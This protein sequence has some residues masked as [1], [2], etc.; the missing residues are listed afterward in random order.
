[1][2][3]KEFANEERQILVHRMKIASLYFCAPLVISFTFVDYFFAPEKQLLFLYARLCVIPVCLIVYYSYSIKWIEEKFP[4]GPAFLLA[5]YFGLYSAFLVRE[6]GYEVSSYYA[7]INLVAIIAF[8]FLPWKLPYVAV[9]T[10]IIYSPY[11]VVLMTAPHSLDRHFWVPNLAF[12]GSTCFLTISSFLVTREL[13]KKEIQAR[14]NLEKQNREQAQIIDQKTREGVFME[15]LANQFA[16]QIVEAIKNGDLTLEKTSRREITCL[17]LDIE[18]ST[19]RSSRIDYSLYTDLMGEFFSDCITLFLKQ[20]VTIGTFLGDG[21]LAFANAPKYDPDHRKNVIQAGLAI[22]RAHDK[23]KNYYR[24]KWRTDFNVRIGIETGFATVGFF[25]NKNRG[26]YT[27]MGE[28]VNLTSRLCS[29]AK[30]NSICVTKNFL[31]DLNP[32]GN[33]LQVQGHVK[34][35][36]LKGFEGEIFELYSIVPKLGFEA[37]DTSQKCVLCAHPMETEEDLGDCAFLK[38]TNCGYKDIID[39]NESRKSAA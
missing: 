1:M 36:D 37:E 15:R 3:L 14:L 24:E 11:L 6:S 10:S 27:A 29:R 5:L 12:I 25:P 9:F 33:D 22:L 31:K 7:G 34:A 17:F 20:N 16:P 13:R 35:Q 30:P 21:I 28:T 38:C 32:N 8:G 18:N 19:N 26:A 39:K 2:W 23:K 4:E